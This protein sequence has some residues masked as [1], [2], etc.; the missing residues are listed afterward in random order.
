[1][2]DVLFNVS[3]RCMEQEKLDEDILLTHLLKWWSE[4]PLERAKFV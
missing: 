4:N 1:L 3:E 2:D